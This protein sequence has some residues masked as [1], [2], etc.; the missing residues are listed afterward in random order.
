VTEG[1]RTSDNGRQLGAVCF[2][3]HL[4]LNGITARVALVGRIFWRSKISWRSEEMNAHIS[5]NKYGK[6]SKNV[7]VCRSD[8]P[9]D[10][11]R[12]IIYY[13]EFGLCRG[14]TDQSV[15]DVGYYVSNAGR[16]FGNFKDRLILPDQWC[17]HP[18]HI[19]LTVQKC[20]TAKWTAY[21]WR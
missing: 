11:W 8:R 17:Y 12:H 1:R 6:G 2:F 20:Q 19:G 16:S 10:G 14:A 5:D 21:R 7:G 3:G 13:Q 15:D 18:N 9:V 4:P